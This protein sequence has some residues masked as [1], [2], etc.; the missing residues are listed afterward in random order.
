MAVQ[1][2]DQCIKCG[3]CVP[4]CPSQALEIVDSEGMVHV[5]ADKC[6]ECGACI[7]TCPVE[8]LALPGAA[9]GT[10]AEPV[11]EDTKTEKPAGSGCAGCPGCG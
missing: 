7:P 10:T 11:A 5:H 9:A 4:A 2:N 8:A 3:T 6:T 1:V